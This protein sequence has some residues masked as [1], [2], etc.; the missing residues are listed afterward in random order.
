MDVLR[1]NGYRREL[2]EG[3]MLPFEEK[4]LASGLCDFALPASFVSEKEKKWI[5]YDVSGYTCLAEMPV[6]DEDLLLEVF[7][8]TLANLAKASEFLIDPAKVM[9]GPETVYFNPKKRTVRFAYMPVEESS[10]AA[11]VRSLSEYLASR[12]YRELSSF[13]IK[14]TDEMLMRNMQPA[15]MAAHV[16]LMRRRRPVC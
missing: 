13:I 14:I 7:E 9:L 6:L 15:E 5:V 2:G 11:N 8:K 3:R 1:D 16:A 10:V 12:S 4:V